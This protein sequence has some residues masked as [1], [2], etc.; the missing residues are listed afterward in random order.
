MASLSRARLFVFM[1]MVA[2]LVAPV[3]AKYIGP[4]DT[5]GALSVS[6]ILAK[7]V[8]EQQVTL[9][10]RLLRK[11]GDEKYVFSDGT[12]EIAVE[13]DDDDFPDEPID[14]KIKVQIQGEVDTGL[15][16]PPEIEVKAITIV[17]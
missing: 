5:G 2:A 11:T 10:G 6:A 4:S 16:R 8:D 1:A 13:I 9:Q 15:R 7:P 17:R 12:A 14:D 3:Y